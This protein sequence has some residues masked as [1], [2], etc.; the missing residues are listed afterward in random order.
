MTRRRPRL[1]RPA[2]RRGAARGAGRLPRPGARRGRRAGARRSSPAATRRASD[3]V[4][5]TLARRGARRIAF[6]DPSHPE[7][8]R[9]AARAGLEPVPVAVDEQGIRRRRARR[10]PTS[11]RV[12]LTPAHQHPTGVGALRRAAARR[13]SPGCASAAR[14]PSRTTTTPSTATTAPPSARSRASTPTASSTPARRAR[15]WRPRCGS[16]GSCVPPSAGRAVSRP[17][18]PRR[19]R[20]RPHR[21]ARVRRLPR[22]RRAR[23]PPAAH[24]RPLP[25]AARRARRGARPRRSPRPRCAASPPGCTPPSSCPAADDE[26]AIV[27]EARRRAHRLATMARDLGRR[28]AGRPPM[29]PARLRR[30]S[31]EAA[32]R[33]AVRA[34]AEAIRATRA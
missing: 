33:P 7:Q 6:E 30:R 10:A 25:R 29:P 22:P 5:R 23:P 31:P 12:V 8:R 1:R 16:A 14:S 28:R 9:V 20:H 15:R 17:R 26:Q 24:A 32:I 27:D 11:T 4:C 3:L 2:R 13:C 21:A 19:L 34:L 18:R